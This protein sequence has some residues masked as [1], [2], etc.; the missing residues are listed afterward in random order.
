M[1]R[2][3]SGALL[4]CLRR[5]ARNDLQVRHLR[6]AGENFVLHAFGEVGVVRIALRL[7][8]GKTAIDLLG[9]V[10]GAS[11]SWHY[12]GR[13]NDREKTAPIEIAAPI[14]TT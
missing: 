11:R 8:N 12:S 14:T 3:F 7:S 6:Q 13:C 2:K 10:A 1:S 5:S 9:N 4:K